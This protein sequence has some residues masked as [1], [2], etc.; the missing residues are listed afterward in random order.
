MRFLKILGVLILVVIAL[1]MILMLTLP[2]SQQ[3]K[4]T[5]TINASAHEV[6]EYLIKLENFKT[7]T[8]WGQGDST[9]R[10][11]ITGKDGE[12]GSY[13]SW[14]GDAT[15]AGKGKIEITGLEMNREIEHIISF[16]NPEQVDTKSEFDLLAVNGQTKLSW[17]YEINTPRPFNIL[18]LFNRLEKSI[19]KDVDQ[20]LRN[21]KLA[22]EGKNKSGKKIEYLPQTMNFPAT[23]YATVRQT[24]TMQEIPLFY[25]QQLPKL[26][27][28]LSSKNIV[29]GVPTSL[30]FSWNEK[31]GNTDMAAALA[32]P[33]ENIDFD[34]S[35]QVIQL[36]GSKALYVDYFGP[37]DKSMTAYNA[38]DKYVADKKWVQKPPVIEQYLNDPQVV[39][40]SSKWHT[41][42]IFLLE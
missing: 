38:L 3:I 4:R 21:I 11:V 34:D 40:D 23:S 16:Y 2:S 41:K 30:Y 42:I 29:P 28:A 15:K 14:S 17:Q 9:V 36:P 37:Y 20:G 26:Y 13:N 27:S 5:I 24:I 35:I 18:N 12:L 33:T 19:G 22:V 8:A 10:N 25:Q 1:L 6:Y 7:W 32:I 39:K 31:A